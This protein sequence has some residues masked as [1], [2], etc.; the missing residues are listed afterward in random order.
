MDPSGFQFIALLI[1]AA[2]VVRL[3]I[4]QIWPQALK[5]ET[6]A[7]KETRYRNGQM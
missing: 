7:E 3:V 4:G 2:V 6:E 5:P 1:G